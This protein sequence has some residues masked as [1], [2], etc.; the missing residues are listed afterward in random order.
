MRVLHKYTLFYV[1]I[2]NEDVFTF[3]FWLFLFDQ[4]LHDEELY[5]VYFIESLL[6]RCL[7]C[8]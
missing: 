1:C 2:P 6:L 4:I 7:T 3:W 8:K 5:S